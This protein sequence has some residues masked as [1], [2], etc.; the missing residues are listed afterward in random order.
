MLGAI[1]GDM[2]GSMYEFNNVK[3]KGKCALD[4]D[5]CKDFPILDP[6]MRMTDDSLLTIAVAKTLMAH[7]PMV[8]TDEGVKRF[9]DDLAKEFVRT[10]KSHI[11]AGFGGM[12]YQWCSLCHDKKQRMPAYGSFGNGGPM[13]VSPVAWIAQS[14]EE[15]KRL[16]RIVTEITHDHIEG[17]KGAEAV[18]LAIYLAL[19]GASKEEIRRRM[20]SEYYPEIDTLDF[21]DLVS[22]YRFSSSCMGSVPQA[23]YCFLISEDMEDAIRN[24]VAIGGDTDTIGAMCGGIA[25]AYY[26]KDSLSRFEGEFLYFMIDP[27]VESLIEDFHHMIGSHK[28]ESKK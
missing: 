16:S 1:I 7:Y 21:A 8:Y 2:V 22:N 15:L 11:G 17:I 3:L 27:E 10:W 28:M 5:K 26:Q 25:E 18:A 19:H 6:R 24:C 14:E 13:R 23:I 4:P 9:Q 20:V 12:F